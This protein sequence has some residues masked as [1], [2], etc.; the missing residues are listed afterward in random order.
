[1][2]SQYKQA[3][4]IRPNY[5]KAHINL[6]Y[7]LLEKWQAGE[8][9]THFQKALQISPDDPEIQNALAWLLAT[10]S[11]A[12]L[13]NGGQAIELAEKANHLSGGENPLILRTLAAAYAEAGRFDDARQTAQKAIALARATGQSAL[14][15]QINEALNLYTSGLP[16][17]EQEK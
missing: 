2:I 11:Q 5:A 1:A 15:E 9:I 14:A 13:R 12:S 10:S 7:A 8:A 4:Q 17:H 16:F 3:L 6:G